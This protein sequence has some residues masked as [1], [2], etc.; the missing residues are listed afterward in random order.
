MIV[1]NALTADSI[2][3]VNLFG[4]S[5]NVSMI[6]SQIVLVTVIRSKTKH[7]R[8]V[9]IIQDPLL[10]MGSTGICLRPR[11]IWGLAVGIYIL[12]ELNV[13]QIYTTLRVTYPLIL[14][15]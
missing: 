14:I 1:Y 3:V 9:W 13:T 6:Y 7:V 12:Y 10:R 8:T 2:V 4:K 5:Q 11:Y 15:L